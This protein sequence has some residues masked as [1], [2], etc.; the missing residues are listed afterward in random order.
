MAFHSTSSYAYQYSASVV[1][2]FIEKYARATRFFGKIYGLDGRE[3]RKALI[4]C[5]QFKNN[6]WN[7]VR[8]QIK[9]VEK[10]DAYAFLASIGNAGAREYLTAV[11][12][13]AEDLWIFEKKHLSTI[14][15]AKF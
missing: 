3:T 10:T 4:K 12:Y 5:F 13:Q 9:W 1:D 7:I 8:E 14:D 11:K 6:R 15:N 2:S